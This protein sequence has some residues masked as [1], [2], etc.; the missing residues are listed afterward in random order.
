MSECIS[1]ILK[2]LFGWKFGAFYYSYEMDKNRFLWGERHKNY[3]RNIFGEVKRY[4]Y[5]LS[6]YPYKSNVVNIKDLNFIGYGWYH[7]TEQ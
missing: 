7:H 1:W 6:G 3:F 4:N 2:K 5:W